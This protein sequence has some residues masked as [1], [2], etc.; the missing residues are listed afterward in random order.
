MAPSDANIYFSTLS[1]DGNTNLRLCTGNIYTKCQVVLGRGRNANG[2]CAVV[3][4][5]DG[6]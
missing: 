3:G 1:T 6:K 2:P 5:T 4:K